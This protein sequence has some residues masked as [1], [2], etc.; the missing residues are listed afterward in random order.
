MLIISF[1]FGNSIYNIYI[2]NNLVDSRLEAYKISEASAEKLSVFYDSFIKENENLSL[3]I[4]KMPVTDDES[5]TVY[6]VYHTNVANALKQVSINRKDVINYY[7]MTKDEF[8]DSTGL[9]YTDM[10]LDK[11]KKIG[12][13]DGIN[14]ESTKRNLIDYKQ[15]FTYNLVNSIVMLGVTILIIFVYAFSRNKINAV[16]SMLGYNILQMVRDSIIDFFS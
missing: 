11:L 6:N 7:S 10:P 4:V 16:K 8:I 9:F 15:V 5:T 3:A 2:L 12:S 14:I 13:R 1:L